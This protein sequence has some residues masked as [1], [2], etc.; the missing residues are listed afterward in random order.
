[1]QCPPFPA[2]ATTARVSRDGPESSP[3]PP[4][5]ARVHAAS[6]AF[7]ELV[8]LAHDAQD[9]QTVD[10]AAPLELDQGRDARLVHLAGGIE[11]GRGHRDDALELRR[12]VALLAAK[13]DRAII[14]PG[15]GAAPRELEATPGCLGPRLG[16]RPPWHFPPPSPPLPRISMSSA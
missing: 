9:V 13:W 7:G 3:P 12:H 5:P 8:R 14:C 4:A 6:L 11:R 1:N 2:E 15:V 10:P 16:R